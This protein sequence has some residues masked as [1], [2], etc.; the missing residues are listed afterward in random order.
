MGQLQNALVIH[1]SDGRAGRVCMG[2]GHALI[3]SVGW[4]YL[5]MQKLEK[6]TPSKSS[7]VNS[8]VMVLSAF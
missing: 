1:L 3:L 2:L 6:I 4:A 5:P 7:E 8:P